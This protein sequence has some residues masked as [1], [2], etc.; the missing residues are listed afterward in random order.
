VGDDGTYIRIQVDACIRFSQRDLAITFIAHV[1]PREMI[2]NQTECILLGQHT[3]IDCIRFESIPR[4]LMDAG[5]QPL[6][7]D[8]YGELNIKAWSDLFGEIH[9]LWEGLRSGR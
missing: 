7:D 4:A 8:V 3:F 6:A 2:P 1:V 5:E 9:Q